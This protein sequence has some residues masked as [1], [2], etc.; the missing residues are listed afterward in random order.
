MG[1]RGF[2]ARCVLSSLPRGLLQS[3]DCQT[4]PQLASRTAGLAGTSCPSLPA[5]QAAVPKPQGALAQGCGALEGCSAAGTTRTPTPAW[6]A[7]VQ[8]DG[9]E[10]WEPHQ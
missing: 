8:Q 3:G 2:Q 1:T 4:A 5:C 10:C 6:P 9:S 7:A